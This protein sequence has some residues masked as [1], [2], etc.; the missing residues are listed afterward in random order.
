M[1]Y[2]VMT[3][4]VDIFLHKKY[5]HDVYKKMCKLNDYDEL[6]RGGTHPRNE[7][8]TTRYNPNVWFSWM[9][10]NYP[11]T[12]KDMFEILTQVGFSWALDDDGNL[13]DLRYENNKTGNEDY[14]LMCFAEYINDGSYITFQGEEN[15]DTYRYVYDS[16]KMHYYIGEIDIR[17][18]HRDVYDFGKLSKSDQELKQLSEA[19]K[20]SIA[21]KK[22]IGS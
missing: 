16:G 8:Y 2:Y 5:F 6:K 10:Y 12:C 22:A 20:A 4:D 17:W 21:E 18:I 11:E 19:F 13:V 1:G 3:T 14:F 9:E 7:E 15:Y